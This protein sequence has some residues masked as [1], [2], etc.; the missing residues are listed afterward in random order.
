MELDYKQSACILC[1]I[2]CGVK[3]G[4]SEGRIESVKG[5]PDHP[6]SKGYI[7]EKA[8]QLNRYQNGADRLDS[9]LRRRPDGSFEAISWDTAIA[10]VAAGLAAIRDEHGGEAIFHYGGGAQGNHLVGAY[11]RATRAT[12]GARYTSN[13]LAQEKTGEFWVDGQLFGK[14]RCHTAPDFEHAQVALFVGKN[15]FQSHGF[16][17]ARQVL[18]AISKDPARTLIVIDPRKTETAALADIHLQVRPGGDAWLLGA[19]VATLLQEDLVDSGFIAERTA[20]FD[21]LTAELGAVPVAEWAAKAGVAEDD[22]RRVARFIAAGESV[23]V[24]E[25]L[26]VQQAHHST[27]NSWLEKLLYLLTGNFGV[28]GGMNLHSRFASLGGGKGAARG[29]TPAGNR[30]VAGLVACND[31]PDE[32][33]GDHDGRFRGMIVESANPAHSLADSPRMREALDAL[34]FLVV[35]DVAMTETARHA[36]YVLPASSQFEKWEMTFFNLEFPHNV[37][38]LRPPV[39]PA[40]PG[41]LPEAEIHAR[42][43]DALG[44]LDGLPVDELTTAAKAGRDAYAMTFMM[45][46]AGNPDVMRRAPALLYATMGACLPEGAEATAVVWALAQT[47]AMSFPASLA[48]AGFEGDNPLAV[49]NA[50][51]QAMLDSPAGLVFTVDEYDESFGRIETPDGRARLVVPEL[52]DEL[53]SLFDTAPTTDDAYPFVLAAGER[54]SSTANTLYRD[55][56]WRRGRDRDARL[57]VAPADAERLGLVDGGSARVT[58]KRGS[59]VAT[60]ELSDTLQPGHCSLPN[61]VGLSYR[62]EATDGVAPNELTASEDK[63]WLA[64]TPWHKHVRARIEAV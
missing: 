37:V 7:C 31:I 39:L 13:A 46:A 26:G 3:L 17:R 16:H 24:L 8:T 62:G 12:L 4:L 35:I 54:R 49:A 50:L 38:H 48:R 6:A 29:A 32:I 21:E 57:R 63:D 23:S 47:C 55:P 45:A 15:P 58:T 59:A 9:P 51:F 20:G 42:L 5:D 34:E 2:N 60:V 40:R 28:R 11:G 43:V 22:V 53:R 33:L 44:G 64:G 27:L 14:A 30:I 25:D 1:S 61:G 52:V 18:R 19:L 10:E 56:E 41:T 36:H